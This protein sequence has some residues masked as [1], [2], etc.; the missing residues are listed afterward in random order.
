MAE[1]GRPRAFDRQQALCR[2]MEIFWERGY[3]G[4]SMAELTA[5][6]GIAAPSLYAA[7]GSKDGLFREALALYVTAEG[8]E[9]RQEV[10]RARSAREAVEALLMGSAR[11]YTRQGRPNGCLVVLSALQANGGNEAVRAELSDMRMQNIGLLA[12]RLAAAMETGEI[13]RQ[14]D[15]QVIARFYV[16]V[17]QGMSIQA[18]D[19]ARQAELE[20]VAQAALAAWPALVSAG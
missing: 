10:Q 14:A 9:I 6:M 11:V 17:Q 20:A 5:A 13:A 1:R 2:A 3:E 15:P 12:N 4:T 19:G 7:F 18:R 16:T 8:A